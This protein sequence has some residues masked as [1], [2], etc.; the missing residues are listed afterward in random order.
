M[1]VSLSLHGNGLFWFLSDRLDPH[2]MVHQPSRIRPHDGLARLFPHPIRLYILAAVAFR[3]AIVCRRPARSVVVALL[4]IDSFCHLGQ[5]KRL[6]VRLN[7]L[8]K[9]A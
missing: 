2:P 8:D 7:E 3:V 5:S 9:K 1:H 4:A 6:A